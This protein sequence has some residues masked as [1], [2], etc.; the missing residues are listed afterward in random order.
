MQRS[1]TRVPLLVPFA[2][3][4]TFIPKITSRHILPHGHV[5]RRNTVYKRGGFATSPS[6]KVPPPTTCTGT[7]R[8][9]T[10]S[11]VITIRSKF[12]YSQEGIQNDFQICEN[13]TFYFLSRT[14]L[15][16]VKKLTAAL[17]K[18]ARGCLEFTHE[19]GGAGGHFFKTQTGEKRA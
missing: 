17:A 3:A 9:K 19:Q 7:L 5:G 6:A 4:F 8:K 11:Q 15:S 16:R 10:R 18:T 14:V 2:H 12:P 13:M 1:R